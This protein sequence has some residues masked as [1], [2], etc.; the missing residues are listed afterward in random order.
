MAS[1]PH[2]NHAP[3]V[4]RT[5]SRYTRPTTQRGA[6]PWEPALMTILGVTAVSV[7]SQGQAQ[8]SPI[9]QAQQ[10][11]A[12]RSAENGLSQRVDLVVSLESSEQ[13]E[14]IQL[15]IPEARK[16][17][18]N[19][20]DFAL[21]DTYS[22]LE[23][24]R[25][26]A[27]RLEGAVPWKL[28]LLVHSQS[29]T[30]PDNR[31]SATL[32]TTSPSSENQITTSST[33]N[34]NDTAIPTAH[35][36]QTISPPIATESNSIPMQESARKSQSS[37]LSSSPIAF[38]HP[39]PVASQPRKS[40]PTHKTVASITPPITTEQR[41]T[42]NTSSLTLNT[43]IDTK[44]SSPTHA[45]PSKASMTAE[46]VAPAPSIKKLAVNP[47]LEYIFIEASSN[48]D[49]KRFSDLF[50]DPGKFTQITENG[51]RII[52]FGVY[53]RN[54]VGRLMMKQRLAM[55]KESGLKSFIVRTSIDQS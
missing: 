6:K 41:R 21:L 14:L 55:L 42:S 20:E 35:R 27:A 1:P 45:P 46:A 34:P 22:K 26:K 38:L 23:I 25:A 30:D 11:T 7:F 31:S 33:L 2:P 15:L 9:S 36:D 49:F 44:Q 53:R 52:Q 17:T 4:A 10:F 28:E 37:S 43:N 48:Q 47:D 29:P 50:G 13:L 24:A 3:L 5:I 51:I 39:R 16:I 8:A 32:A 12:R 19:G 18:L 40:H 54:R